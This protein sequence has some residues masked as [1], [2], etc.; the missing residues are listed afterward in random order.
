LRTTAEEEEEAELIL[1]LKIANGDDENVSLLLLS[2]NRR[3]IVARRSIV[4]KEDKLKLF[5]FGSKM[6][7]KE[8]FSEK[9]IGIDCWNVAFD[10]WKFPATIADVT[11]FEYF[12][13][14]KNPSICSKEEE[15]AFKMLLLV[16]FSHNNVLK[17][18]FEIEVTTVKLENVARRREFE[19]FKEEEEVTFVSSFNNFAA[20]I[21]LLFIVL[22][23]AWTIES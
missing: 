20:S 13:L 4:C 7:E 19:E 23:F 8:E 15:E 17:Q 16:K 6:E 12:D 10:S 3:E 21:L 1:S 11:N 14:N 18:N 9:Q 2:L 22:L 5:I